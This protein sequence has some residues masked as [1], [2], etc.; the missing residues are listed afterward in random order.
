MQQADLTDL[1]KS[2]I[3]RLIANPY[4]VSIKPKG[5]CG[6]CHETIFPAQPTDD[7]GNH[8]AC[9]QKTH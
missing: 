3:N 9:V 5:T 4:T 1:N 8:L 2:R 7:N 6:L